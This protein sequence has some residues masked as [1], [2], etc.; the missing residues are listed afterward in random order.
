MINEE[1]AE[2]SQNNKMYCK[3]QER[4]RKKETKYRKNKK[5]KKRKTQENM[6]L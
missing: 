2:E 4:K 3:R 6:G 1:F 5:Q